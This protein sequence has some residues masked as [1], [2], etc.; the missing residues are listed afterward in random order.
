MSTN[1]KHSD[2][3]FYDCKY[4]LLL[5]LNFQ[6][7]NTFIMN[8]KDTHVNIEKRDKLYMNLGIFVVRF[9]QITEYMRQCI[10]WAFH[11]CG[12][13]KQE[14]IRTMTADLTA[15]PLRMQLLTISHQIYGGDSS[16]YK[17][18]KELL[19]EVST[20]ITR[21]NKIVHGH[22]T[23]FA[24]SVYEKDDFEV[25]AHFIKDVKTKNGL[26]YKLEELDVEEFEILNSQLWDILVKFRGLS[27]CIGPGGMDKTSSIDL[28]IYES[29]KQAKE[30]T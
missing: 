4:L 16:P 29:P 3:H 5:Y 19:D 14:I 7:P 27:V 20:I 10:L 25:K 26:S 30:K 11:R 21:R 6:N 28:T 13:N 9:E 24:D 2:R 23:I 18:I 12:L 17:V 22:W 15:E 1:V 8:T